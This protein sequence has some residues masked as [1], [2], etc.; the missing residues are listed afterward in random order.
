ME[1]QRVTLL[2]R[3]ALL[4]ACFGSGAAIV[5]NA[6]GRPAPV[7]A[8]SDGDVVLGAPNS[9]TDTTSISNT[10]NN[11]TVFEANTSFAGSTAISAVGDL[12]GLYANGAEAIVAESDQYGL[13]ATGGFAGVV[14]NAPGNGHMGVFGW[15]D[16]GIGVKGQS[17]TAA[18]VFGTADSASGVHGSSK[19]NYG[20][21][22]ESNAGPGVFGTTGSQS[23][24][25][26]IGWSAGAGV[27]GASGGDVNL[28]T[29]PPTKT[30]VFGYAAQDASAVGVYGR[31]TVGIGVRAQADAGGTALRVD[32]KATFSRMGTITVP[33]GSKTVT[34]SFAGLTSASLIFAVVRTGDGSVWVRKA[35]ASSGSLKVYLN[36]VVSRRTTIAWVAFG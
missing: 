33:T 32:G 2:T 13:K 30:G 20:V 34:K 1:S 9:A 18:G 22:G 21:W 11:K 24:P 19:T 8:G 25:G 23:E 28:P 12:R 15:S 14:G 27:F 26:V 10:T 6:L 29:T 7:R 5:S 31:S 4:A 3:R 36:K 35:Q 17:E 16:D